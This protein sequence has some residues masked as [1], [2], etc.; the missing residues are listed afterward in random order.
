MSEFLGEGALRSKVKASNVKFSRL[1]EFFTDCLE[2]GFANPPFSL[3]G[4]QALL[5]AESHCVDSVPASRCKIKDANALGARAPGVG[6]RAR[7]LVWGLVFHGRIPAPRRNA[8]K[9]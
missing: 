6:G 1:G 7:V 5:P 4:G 9:E 8:G 3:R 2:A